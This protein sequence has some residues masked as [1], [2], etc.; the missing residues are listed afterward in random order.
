VQKSDREIMEILE[1]FDATGCAHSAAGIVGVDPKT[2]RRYVE[3]RDEGQPVAGPAKR[4]RLIDPFLAKIEEWVDR[5]EG[6]VRADVV[7]ERLAGL[8][9]IGDERT[10]RRAVAGAKEG[11]RAGRRRRY[12]PWI[13][14]P[15]RETSSLSHRIAPRGAI[16][17]AATPRPYSATSRSPCLLRSTPESSARVEMACSMTSS[18]ST[19]LDFIP[20]PVVEARQNDA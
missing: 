9:F 19:V 15:D 16:S 18:V 17:R 13:T 10:I 14:E 4:P 20:L 5:S 6:K 1:A 12:R 7:H 11:W 8:G 3:A 2:V